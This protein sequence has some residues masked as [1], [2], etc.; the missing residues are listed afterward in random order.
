MT[1]DITLYAMRYL[2]ILIKY[3]DTY[4]IVNYIFALL[5]IFYSRIL[6]PFVTIPKTVKTL[7]TS[8]SKNIML[9]V[10][11]C[12]L[13]FLI[14]LV[15]SYICIILSIY[16]FWFSQTT[17]EASVFSQ[18]KLNFLLKI[19]VSMMTFIFLDVLVWCYPRCKCD[20]CY[21]LC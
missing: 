19:H 14:F 2:L 5:V 6:G 16:N 8:L 17:F 9:V 20:N 11:L 7:C 13:M 12:K 1:L 10:F 18:Q 21:R 3:F 4:S 15:F